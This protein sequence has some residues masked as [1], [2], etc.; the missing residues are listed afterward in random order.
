MV[1]EKSEPRKKRISN[2]DVFH[3]YRV[4]IFRDETTPRVAIFRK[5]FLQCESMKATA[6]PL[7][8]FNPSNLALA[9]PRVSD[10]LT[11]LTMVDSSSTSRLK[12]SPK[13]PA[14][15]N[16]YEH[17]IELSPAAILSSVSIRDTR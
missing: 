8:F 16:E 15:K 4:A 6:C 17:E 7:A 13:L 2:E 12:A 11:R 3:R 5:K 9:I 1:L 14:M 10:D